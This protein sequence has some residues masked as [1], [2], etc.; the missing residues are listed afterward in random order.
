MSRIYCQSVLAGEHGGNEVVDA[1]G[2]MTSGA[3]AFA[4]G[5]EGS[6]PVLVIG[7]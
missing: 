1:G 6:L 4:L 3:C 7:R 2:S 5:L